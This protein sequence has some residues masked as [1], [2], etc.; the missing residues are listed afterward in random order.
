MS[1]SAGV[2]LSGPSG[3]RR[4][5]WSLL[6][7]TAARTPGSPCPP[8]RPVRGGASVRLSQHSDEHGPR[9][10][11]LLPVDEELSEVTRSLS[12]TPRS[13]GCVSVPRSSSC[14]R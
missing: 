13:P 6:R 2:E 5:T 7:F 4:R 9:H 3:H 10:Q 14:S 12:R 8:L 1:S 11:I